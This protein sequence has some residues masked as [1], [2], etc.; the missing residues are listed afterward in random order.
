MKSWLGQSESL[1]Q[2]VSIFEADLEVS[3]DETATEVVWSWMMQDAG[4]P[5]SIHKGKS[6]Q[7]H[8]DFIGVCKHINFHR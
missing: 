5:L 4:I 8:V 3:I 1:D 2:R 6:C 7:G